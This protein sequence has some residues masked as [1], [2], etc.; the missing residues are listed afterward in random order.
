MDP[1]MKRSY[2]G[3]LKGKG[4]TYAWDGNEVGQGRMEITEAATNRV[5]LDLDFV[6]PFEAHNKVEFTL[7]PKGDATELTWAMVGPVPYPAKILH[8]FVN[9]DRMVGSQFEAGLADLKTL[10]EK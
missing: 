5:A 8:V 6:K 7:Q 4:A 1:A 2:G 10:T 9:M 3:A